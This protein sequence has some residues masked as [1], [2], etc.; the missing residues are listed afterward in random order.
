MATTKAVEYDIVIEEGERD[1]VLEVNRR[2]KSGAWRPIGGPSVFM[3]GK[4]KRM[5]MQAIVKS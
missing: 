1:L 2:I 4:N 5:I 3:N